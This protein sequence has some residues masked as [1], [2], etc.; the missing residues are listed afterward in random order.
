MI[1]SHHFPWKSTNDNVIFKFN[2]SLSL[3]PVSFATYFHF[4]IYIFIKG[5]F[6][7]FICHHALKA[8]SYF[9]LKFYYF[10]SPFNSFL[11]M[12]HFYRL[13]T[14]CTLICHVKL[15][16]ER[17]FALFHFLL[18]SCFAHDSSNT[19]ETINANRQ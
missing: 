11:K 9:N 1:L 10:R 18:Y 3:K 7:D 13:C 4:I 19:M 2:I 12:Y 8:M 5:C 14:S 15:W 16:I 6:K 17:R